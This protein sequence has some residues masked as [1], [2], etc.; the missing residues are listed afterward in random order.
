MDGETIGNFHYGYVGRSVFLP[1]VLKSAAGM[2]QLHSGTSSINYWKTFFD[3][4]AD[5][6]DIQWGID[7]Y[8]DEH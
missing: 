2:Y 4:P 5:Q 3:D 7:M 8:E 1:V 6:E